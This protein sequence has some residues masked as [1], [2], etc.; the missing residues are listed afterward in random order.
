[1]F[2]FWQ[3]NKPLLREKRFFVAPVNLG[4]MRIAIFTSNIK[5]HG[6]IVVGDKDGTADYFLADKSTETKP[7]QAGEVREMWKVHQGELKS[8]HWLEDV[9]ATRY[10]LVDEDSGGTLH[11]FSERKHKD[12]SARL[13][14]YTFLF[15]PLLFVK[16][17][18]V[19]VLSQ[20]VD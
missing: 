16:Q 18:S 6:G 20:H 19:I 5:K 1:M 3:K 17:I 13:S 2:N 4:A 10:A 12:N 14:I 15:P 8:L 9:L 7:K 11:F